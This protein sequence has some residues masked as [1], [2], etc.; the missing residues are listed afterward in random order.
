MTIETL[1][2][3]VK[4]VVQFRPVSLLPLPPESNRG[5]LPST[6]PMY[7]TGHS[8]VFDFNKEG[9]AL[10]GNTFLPNAAEPA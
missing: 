3:S 4:L 7:A 6:G 5:Y 1:S 2:K 8:K 10:M 9:R